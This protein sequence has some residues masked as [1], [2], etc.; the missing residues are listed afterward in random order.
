MR[1]AVSATTI[2]IGS[3][4]VFPLLLF[5]SA[6]LLRAQSLVLGAGLNVGT[7]PRALE[8]LCASA[9]RLRGVGAT[10]RAGVGIGQLQIAATLDYVNRLGARD[11][12]DCVAPV[13]IRTD[14]SF[15][16]AGNSA[17]SLGVTAW[18]ALVQGI[19]AGAEVGSVIGHSSWFVGP[20]VGA[21]VGHVRVEVAAHWHAVSF[22]AI[23]R[24][25][26]SGTTHEISRKSESQRSWGGVARVLLVRRSRP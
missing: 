6:N 5:T 14:S 26:G 11:A 4:I 9:R 12:A 23:T 13:G 22:D 2:R 15:A 24:D 7:I 8:P 18:I 10:A 20:A 17:A 1:I 19:G 3:A 25:Y 16:D 21:Q